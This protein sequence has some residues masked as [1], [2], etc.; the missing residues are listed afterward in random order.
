MFKLLNRLWNGSD[1]ENGSPNNSRNTGKP[2][3]T[4]ESI[5]SIEDLITSMR[6]GDPRWAPGL[7]WWYKDDPKEFNKLFNDLLYRSNV[8]TPNELPKVAKAMAAFKEKVSFMRLNQD[9]PPFKAETFPIYM[10]TDSKVEALQQCTFVNNCH[11]LWRT[12]YKPHLAN[13][14]WGKDK[15]GDDV[16]LLLEKF[17]KQSSMTNTLFRS[18]WV[19]GKAADVISDTK[20]IAETAKAIGEL[21]NNDEIRSHHKEMIRAC[22]DKWV[23]PPMDIMNSTYQLERYWKI[24][25]DMGEEIT[26]KDKVEKFQRAYDANTFPMHLRQPNVVQYVM[27]QGETPTYD[28][29]KQYAIG[30]VMKT[31]EATAIHAM[32]GTHKRKRGTPNGEGNSSSNA[33]NGS[34]G[35]QN[36]PTKRENTKTRKF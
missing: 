8:F 12:I 3:D 18:K 14:P 17:D 32:R 5:E 34:K 7:R 24:L 25:E 30:Y 6:N 1:S 10:K 15:A 2:D 29:L 16:I 22:V 33:T 21:Y 27:T 31:I 26:D 13:R 35:K 28:E 23:I 20:T 19:H 11:N 9:S 36:N 4:W